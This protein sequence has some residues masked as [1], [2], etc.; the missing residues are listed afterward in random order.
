MRSLLKL[1]AASLLLAVAQL[2]AQGMNMPM[3]QPAAKAAAVP[4]VKAEVRKVDE[5]KG[6]VILKHEEIP[7]LSMSAMTMAFGVTDKKMLKGLQAGDKVRFQ[8]DSVKGK[9]MVTK[10]ERSR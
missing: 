7:N 10:L 1:V 3:D 6:T 5:A 8:V 4:F 2:H 9:L